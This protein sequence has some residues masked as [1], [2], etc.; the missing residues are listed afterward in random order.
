[1]RNYRDALWDNPS[2]LHDAIID[3]VVPM[4]CGGVASD[5]EKDIADVMHYIYNLLFISQCYIVE[6]QR[7]QIIQIISILR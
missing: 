4:S 1:M 7:F 3:S 2:F 6:E 5:F